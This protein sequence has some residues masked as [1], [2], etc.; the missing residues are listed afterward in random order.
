MYLNGNLKTVIKTDA[1][2]DKILVQ[3]FCTNCTGFYRHGDFP[4]RSK[5]NQNAQ[6]KQNTLVARSKANTSVNHG[7]RRLYVVSLLSRLLTLRRTTFSNVSFEK[8]RSR[9]SI[10]FVCTF[11]NC[12][13]IGFT[14]D[15]SL[16]EF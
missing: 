3:L 9:S 1:N 5:R 6:S 15:V 10:M 14:S 8:P 13:R 12:M 7:F 4:R 11:T 2:T 16:P